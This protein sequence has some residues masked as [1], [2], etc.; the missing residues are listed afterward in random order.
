VVAAG[1][2][3]E[4]VWDD[5]S[6]NEQAA[7]A[8]DWVG[9]WA[10]DEQLFPDDEAWRSVGLCTGR[11]FGKTRACAEWVLQEV[12]EGRAM[13]IALVAQNED[14]TREVM[15]DGDSGLVACSPPWFPA[16]YE[17]GRLL[18]PNGAQAFVFT[19]ER[20]GDIRGP[21]VHLSWCTEYVAWPTTKRE[22]AR[23]N[24]RLMTR[25]GYARELWDTTPKARHPI[26]RELL[27]RAARS[28]ERHRVIRGGTRANVANLSPEAIKEWEEEMG[29][30]QRGQEELEG[31]FR[32][33]AAGA[34]WRQ[35][36][37][38]AHRRSMPMTL[39]RRTLAVDPS[40][41]TRPGTDGTGIDES[42]LGDDGQ[43]YALDS[44]SKQ[45]AWEEWGDIAV[46]RYVLGRCDCLTLERNRG[47]DSCTANVRAR[48]EKYGRDHGVSLRV[49]VV[50]P[51]AVTRHVPGVIYVKE[52][53]GRGSK[54]TRAEPVASHYESGRVSHVEGANLKDLEDVLTTWV[55]DEG[56]DSPNALDAHVYNVIE[57]AGLSRET[58][59]KS[60]V[61]GA[62]KLQAMASAQRPATAPNI[63]AMMP[64]RR[65]GG[66]RI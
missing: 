25:L 57:L 31:V 13:R 56:G 53:I 63:A 16:T 35:A 4:S 28:P 21:G 38:D 55:P 47:G 64:G 22:E 24:V 32:D 66:D 54:G 62:A 51:D 36:W 3:I 48:A 59:P 46:K 50:R 52:V 37:I 39:I 61:L 60:D 10:R 30:T 29:G 12:T 45:L 2:I 17:L 7:L 58:K 11:G 5:L 33:D 19:P 8:Y 65:G 14:K 44:I 18:W 34:L 41:S 42:G 40:I 26:I 27:A 43:V 49:E 15:I 9:F 23:S 1:G 20:P 6:L